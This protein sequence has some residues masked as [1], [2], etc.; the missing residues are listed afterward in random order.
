MAEPP[1]GVIWNRLKAG[2]VIPFLGAG[3]SLGHRPD[4]V[5]WS[6]T[7]PQFFPSGAELANLLADESQYP[8]KD[9]YDRR[10]LSKV[11]SY[12]GDISGRPELRRRLR[13]VFLHT[14]VTPDPIHRLIALVDR[15]LLVVVTN[16][17]NLMEQAFKEAN[18]PYDLVVHQADRKE[19]ANSVLW[20]PHGAQNPL[21]VDPNQL[22]AKID[23]ATTTVVYKMHGTVVPAS[24]EWDNFVI[25]EEDYVDFLSRMTRNEAIPAMFLT[26]F[27]DR[28]FLFLGYSLRD[29]N[30]R[31]IL[32][33][34]NKSFAR[35]ALADD[36]DPVPSWAIQAHPTEVECAL[37]GK[38]NVN[39]FDI[40]IDRFAGRM[41]ELAV[42]P[43]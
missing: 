43:P 19:F 40:E 6:V 3:A 18:R 2:N 31:V 10:D 4:N 26:H 24:S 38:R 23:L 17:D 33:N 14:V 21:P 16:Y 15:P 7:H 36:S 22:A 5:A 29:W 39:I 32:K 8:S 37:W 1:Y 41:R 30:L 42:C 13:E 28:S 35:H 34:I 20:W 12:Y 25:T 11:S 27:R 9:K